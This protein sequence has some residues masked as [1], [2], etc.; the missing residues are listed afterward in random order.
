MKKT[1]CAVLMGAA[2]LAGGLHLD[3][4]DMSTLMADPVRYRVVTADEDEIVF[5][6]MN[7][8]AAIQT[9]DYP[10]SLENIHVNLYV[11]HYRDGK[12]ITAMDWTNQNIMSRIDEYAVQISANR[13]TNSIAMK[14][15]LTAS[16]KP[17][18]T[19]LAKTQEKWDGDAEDLYINLQL[20][21]PVKTVPGKKA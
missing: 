8:M 21:P 5:A 16:W 3:A 19:A 4:M 7:T 17:D 15:S 6:D 9:R 11:G 12:Q 1:V 14:P 2:F 20:I 18:G 10:V 13:R